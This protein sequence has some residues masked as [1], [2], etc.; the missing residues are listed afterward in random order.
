MIGFEG[1]GKASKDFDMSEF[2]DITDG[3]V[4]YVMNWSEVREF[5]FG[6]EDIHEGV[7]LAVEQLKDLVP[8]K[9]QSGE[10]VKQ[11]CRLEHL[12]SSEWEI[13]LCPEFIDEAKVAGAIAELLAH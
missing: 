3:S 13:R 6:I 8:E 2:G 7:F 12:D 5:S 4:G 1:V 10:L 9:I 11:I